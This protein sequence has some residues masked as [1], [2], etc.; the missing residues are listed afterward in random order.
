MLSQNAQFAVDQA[1]KYPGSEMAVLPEWYDS[2]RKDFDH[3]LAHHTP[4]KHPLLDIQKNSV[5]HAVASKYTAIFDDMGSGKTA[6]ALA[7]SVLGGH[8]H[9]M[10][11]CPNFLKDNW[12][13]EIKKFTDTP[14]SQIFIGK[15]QDL[16][17][18]PSTLTTNFKFF[19][20]NYEAGPVAI[21]T[22]EIF[23]PALKACSHLIFDE[24]HA[25][26]NALTKVYQSWFYFLSQKPPNQLTM[27]SG[28][29]FDRYIGELYAYFQL[30]D[31]NPSV[32]GN[33]FTTTYPNIC[34]W[35]QRFAKPR[36]SGDSYFSYIPS[37]LP[38][39]R[40]IFGRR[41]VRRDILDVVE[42]PP[43]KNQEIEL[44]NHLFDGAKMQELQDKFQK[45]LALMHTSEKRKLTEKEMG[46]M[47]AI[48]NIRVDISHRKVPYTS[49]M[50]EKYIQAYGPVV[51]FF[52]FIKPM[53]QF[54]DGFKK[55]G[56]QAEMIHSK[57]NENDQRIILDRFKE[58]EL[59]VIAATFGTLAEGVNLQVSNTVIFN[60]L[61]WRPL[62][63]SQA[64]RRVWR[65]GQNR[66]CFQVS[67]FCSVDI[68]IR[69]NIYM[70][71]EYIEDLYGILKHIKQ[72][73][74]F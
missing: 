36:G 2:A 17:R 8:Q 4:L 42:L 11:V 73:Q 55:K 48:Q 13:H 58:K 67:M 22:P 15:G 16:V 14:L 26:K 31:L 38:I 7:I 29:P 5:A 3:Y 59:H 25:I 53:E 10:I 63:V 71:T 20:F 45:A 56:Y 34:H 60:D 46:S 57:V 12:I 19:I 74:K 54:I 28:T 9:T 39:V 51:V 1:A 61:P 35:E 37:E 33:P 44:P 27:L 68:F 47:G 49:Q 21:K 66:P 43:L 32:D 41:P 50:T 52:E 72:Q 40:N 70:K 24:V 69:R 64:E 6:Q 18:L 23:P 62:L 30:L 65:I